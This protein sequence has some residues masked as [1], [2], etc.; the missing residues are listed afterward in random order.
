MA[1]T[2]F[3]CRRHAEDKQT[4][5]AKG[6]CLCRRAAAG[7]AGPAANNCKIGFPAEHLGYLG[8]SKYRARPAVRAKDLRG[9]AQKESRFQR[10][11]ACTAQRA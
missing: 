10:Q 2:L 11:R 4:D 8:A 7:C 9:I 6:R 1:P 5:E 3:H